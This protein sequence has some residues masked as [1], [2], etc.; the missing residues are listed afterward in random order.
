MPTIQEFGVIF[1]M[2]GVLV[3]SWDAHF[4]T[5]R[6]CCRRHGRDCTLKE[7]MQGF[8][9]TSREF[10]QE[11]WADPPDDEF[12]KAFD[13]E[14]ELLYRDSIRANFPR[15]PGAIELIRLL[16]SA[17]VPMAV[18]SSG[19]RKNID[20]V[21]R[22][23]GADELIKICISG[24]DVTRG[25]PDPEVFLKAAAAMNLPPARCIVLEDAPVGIEAALA[26]GMKCVGVISS[27]RSA[28][29]LSRATHLVADDLQT[30]SL[31]L[32]EHLVNM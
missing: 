26:A 11:T 14:K 5:W 6:E 4:L 27:G 32:L 12:I 10:I 1:D 30:V 3:D 13:Q 18:G 7:F 24:A 8:G 22:L 9:R 15:M 28:S 19:P 2:D 23:L 17:E 21:L 16:S 29:Q 25:K 20:E 31:S